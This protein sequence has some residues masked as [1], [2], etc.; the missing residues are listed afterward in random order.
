MDDIQLEI[1]QI[2]NERRDNDGSSHPAGGSASK[3]STCAHAST[4][5]N[6]KDAGRDREG[7][8][9]GSNKKFDSGADSKEH[10]E[11][12]TK[13]SGRSELDSGRTPNGND[14]ARGDSERI[15]GLARGDAPVKISKKK[16][17]PER[18][19]DQKEE[20]KK[21]EAKTLSNSEADQYR[22]QIAESLIQYAQMID[23]GLKHY[24]SDNQMPD[25]WGDLSDKEAGAPANILIKLG[26]RNPGAA[27][28][29]RQVIEMEDYIAVGVMFLP[30]F[31]QTVEQMK[32][33]P[34]RER[35]SKR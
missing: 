4:G 25:I 14:Q 3:S 5:A 10:S 31:M 13:S 26:Q 12:S 6:S 30:R 21:P 28:F 16:P 18:S 22:D 15:T 20:K 35:K 24:S 9:S 17:Q 8:G 23:K 33:R 19:T 1:E 34:K 2:R 32:K 29:A 11:R 7:S 27:Q